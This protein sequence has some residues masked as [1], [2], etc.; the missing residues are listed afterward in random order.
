MQSRNVIAWIS[1]GLF[2][3][4][5]IFRERF[6]Y[7]ASAVSFSFLSILFCFFFVCFV[8]VVAVGRLIFIFV[9]RFCTL[10]IRKFGHVRENETLNANE[11][12]VHLFMVRCLLVGY[13]K[14]FVV[15]AVAVDS[16]IA[17]VII[18]IVLRNILK[19]FF[20]WCNVNGYAYNMEY[21]YLNIFFFLLNMKFNR[22][23]FE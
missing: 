15:A 4:K 13:C 3:G 11:F 21:M 19:S 7:F 14:G 16:V 6:Y 9:C 12:V 20:E 18:A 1:F 5:R 23:F 22:R 10:R 17:G 2:F 8:F